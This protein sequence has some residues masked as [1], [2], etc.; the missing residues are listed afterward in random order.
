MNTLSDLSEQL[1]SCGLYVRTDGVTGAILGISRA[2]RSNVEERTEVTRFG[3]TVL[4]ERWEFDDETV[5][6]G[7]QGGVGSQFGGYQS[8]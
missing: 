1:R 6:L 5:Y 3:R 4:V 2:P 7:T 8:R